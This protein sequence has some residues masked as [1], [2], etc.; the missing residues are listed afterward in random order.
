MKKFVR[1]SFKYTCI[2]EIQDSDHTIDLVIVL[3]DNVFEIKKIVY[4]MSKFFCCSK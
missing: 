3:E 2:L 1:Y 4:S